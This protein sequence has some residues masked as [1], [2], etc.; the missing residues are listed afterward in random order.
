MNELPP[1]IFRKW[2]H[3]REEDQQAVTVYRGEDFNFPPARGRDGIE[4]RR[5]GTFVEWAIG[6]G[7]YQQGIN[8]HW[9]AIDSTHVRITVDASRPPRVLEIVE[10][11]GQVLKVR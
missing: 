9:E 6:A 5:D 1:E 2:I 7:D 11:D 8:G 4:F 10:C 3:S